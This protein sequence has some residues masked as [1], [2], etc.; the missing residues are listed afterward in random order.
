VEKARGLNA[1]YSEITF[2][3][4]L[5]KKVA[6]LPDTVVVREHAKAA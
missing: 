4:T 1:P 3:F 2:D 6:D 5:N